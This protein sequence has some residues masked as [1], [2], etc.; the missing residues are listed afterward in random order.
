[1]G[2]A[3]QA[4][5]MDEFTKANQTLI[6]SLQQDNKNLRAEVAKKEED[7]HVATQEIA[8][9]SAD[10]SSASEKFLIGEIFIIDHSNA[11]SFS[12]LYLHSNHLIST[13]IFCF[14]L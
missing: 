4:A 8:R 5:Q 7:L 10:G 14:Q 13:I 9:M 11:V 12:F 3:D 6:A 2:A 1:M